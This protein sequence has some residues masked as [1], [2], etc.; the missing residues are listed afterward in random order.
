MFRSEGAAGAVEVGEETGVEES[1]A[2]SW[3]VRY[4][5]AVWS[6]VVTLA[7]AAVII[8]FVVVC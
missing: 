5:L 7:T 1:A 2:K 6:H 4:G 3:C 8:Y